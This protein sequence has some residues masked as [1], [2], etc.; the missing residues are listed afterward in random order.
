MT[1]RIGQRPM[2]TSAGAA[3]RTEPRRAGPV[4]PEEFDIFEGKSSNR[5]R[6]CQWMSRTGELGGRDHDLAHVT[7]DWGH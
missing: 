7:P 1:A 5:V 4:G 2:V 6:V 3:P